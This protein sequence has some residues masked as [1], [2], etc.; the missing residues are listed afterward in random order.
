MMGTMEP[1]SWWVNFGAQTPFLQTL[2]FRLL[3]QPSSSSCAE[4]NWSTY[5]FIHSLRR[6]KLTTSRAQDLVYIHNNLRLLSRNP[7]D[8]VKMWD[9]GGDAFDSME[10]IFIAVSM[11]FP[12]LEFL[13][14][15]VSRS[16]CKA[17]GSDLRCHFKNTRETA[18]ALRKMSLIKAKRY[19]E[20]VLVH[21]QAI[22]FTRFCRGVGRTAQAKNRHSN[23]QGRWPAK[24]AKFILDLLKNAE[25][26]AEVKGLDVDALFISHIQVNQA[27]KQRRRTY[28]AHGRINPYMSSPC[29]IEL[30]LSE[31][32]EPVKKEADTQLSKSKP[33][34]D[35][36]PANR[37]LYSFSVYVSLHSATLI[38]LSVM[39]A[40]KFGVPIIAMPMQLD[41][42]VNARLVVDL[43]LG[44]KVLRDGNRVL[45]GHKVARVVEQVVLGKLG[46]NMRAK[47]K[48]SG[49]YQI[50]YWCKDES[51]KMQKYILKQ[52]FE[53]FSV[54][55]SEGLHKGY[56]RFQ[57]LLSQLEIHG[58]GVS[59]EDANQ[60]VS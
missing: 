22:P 36:E 39:E 56:D 7:N 10:D 49:R 37:P 48:K 15:A 20:D 34:L 31:K 13:I 43:G 30:T 25:S 5:A 57:S 33:W 60:K 1:K 54:S 35:T 27:Q 58:A 16:P 47:L 23:G 50:R 18:H 51:K 9:V 8:D 53:S 52:Q 32:E 41:Q 46:E 26:N 19:L 17:R 3:G 4:R 6:N 38:E 14:F 24:S 28:R 11:P 44:K 59:T 42:P 2:A 45:S 55:N 21:K 12:Y 40:M 29:H